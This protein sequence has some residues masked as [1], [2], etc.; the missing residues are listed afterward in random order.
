MQG[1]RP[2]QASAER[3]QAVDMHMLA[4]D[5]AEIGQAGGPRAPVQET[6]RQMDGNERFRVLA[7]HRRQQRFRG[8]APDR[9][10]DIV[11]EQ[12]KGKIRAAANL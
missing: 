6:V 2:E 4:D 5:K 7:D 1:Q 9:G 12:N 11:H 3:A 8:R 10:P